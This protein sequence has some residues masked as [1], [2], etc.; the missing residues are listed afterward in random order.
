MYP[1]CTN[2][3]HCMCDLPPLSWYQFNPPS[4]RAIGIIT[5]PMLRCYYYSTA[6]S[7]RTPCVVVRT[8]RV[9]RVIYSRIYTRMISCMLSLM[10]TPILRDTCACNTCTAYDGKTLNEFNYPPIY[11]SI[12]RRVRW[13]VRTYYINLY[14]SLCHASPR[15]SPSLT[16][17]IRNTLSTHLSLSIS[18]SFSLSLSLEQLYL[19]L[20][21]LHPT[22]SH[23]PI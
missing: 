19:L 3:V 11:L 12:S 22:L 13:S 20:I 9:R 15:P 17:H 4:I 7:L 2:Y 8:A 18:L 10:Y 6:M 14:Y 1:V 23:P 21:I 5:Y 16:S